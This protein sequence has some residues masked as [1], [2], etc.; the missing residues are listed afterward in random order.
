MSSWSLIIL[1][2]AWQIS[3]SAHC[4]SMSLLSLDMQHMHRPQDYGRV[5]RRNKKLMSRD[6]AC[7]SSQC[8]LA[9]FY[10]ATPDGWQVKGFNKI[11]REECERV[12]LRIKFVEES[13]TLLCSFLTRPDLSGCLY[14]DCH[15]E[16]SGPSHLRT[17]RHSLLRC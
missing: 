8:D 3:F 17:Q 16:D 13:G 2:T 10:P 11:M 14:P 1:T 12:G 7:L 15:M 6:G 4:V 5:N 9:A